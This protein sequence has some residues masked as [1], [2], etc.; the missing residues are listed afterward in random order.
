MCIYKRCKPTYTREDI[1]KKLLSVVFAA[2]LVMLAAS[3]VCAAPS[4]SPRWANPAINP[5]DDGTPAHPAQINPHAIAIM[6]ALYGDAD[7]DGV[8]NMKDNCPDKANPGQADMDNDLL[9]D[10]CDDDMDG[11]EVLN[12]DDNCDDVANADQADADTDG[13]GDLC[14]ETDT[15]DS[16]GDGVAD[17]SDNCPNTANVDQADEDSD[18][19]GD[20]CDTDAPPADLTPPAA[21]GGEGGCSMLPGVAANPAVFAMLAMALMAFAVRRK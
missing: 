9:G 18:G 15:L 16:D 10:V 8:I 19:T 3:A 17:S 6:Q 13:V 1:M 4:V 7:G 21:A 11:D 12:A 2:A 20:A 5:D 14:E